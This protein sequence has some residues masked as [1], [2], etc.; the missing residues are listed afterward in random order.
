VARTE[1]VLGAIAGKNYPWDN[2]FDNFTI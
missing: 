2:Q 1:L